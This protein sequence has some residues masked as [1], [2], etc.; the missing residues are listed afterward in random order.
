M[1]AWFVDALAH[2]NL[3]RDSWCGSD[4]MQ[5]AF[6][7]NFDVNVDDA[8]IEGVS[9]GCCSAVS[10]C[11]GCIDAIEERWR[12]AVFA[13]EIRHTVNSGAH[14]DPV[15]N[16]GVRPRCNIFN[17]CLRIGSWNANVLSCYNSSIAK[18]RRKC[19]HIR[20]LC[21]VLWFKRRMTTTSICWGWSS[22]K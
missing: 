1:Q 11:W 21:D 20:M 5:N 12:K 4:V 8:T 10:P 2:F 3:R 14:Q 7:C 15:S 19:Q 16:G 22:S 6:R 13:L 18:Y 17:F 9:G